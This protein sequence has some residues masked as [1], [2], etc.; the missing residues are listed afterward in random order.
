MRNPMK[1]VIAI[2]VATLLV[3]H[4]G[5]TKNQGQSGN[6][7]ASATKPVATAPTT[8]PNGGAAVADDRIIRIDAGA[9]VGHTD[10]QG[11]VWL[12]DKGFVGGDVVDRGAVTIEGTKLQK[13]YRTERW[14]MTAYELPVPNGRYRVRLRFVETYDGTDAAGQRVFTV[15]A[16]DQKVEDLDVFKEA[17]GRNKHIVKTLQ[18]I[19]V[20]DGKLKI[21]FTAAEGMNTMISGIEIFPPGTR[22]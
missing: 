3:W 12:A 7:G 2:G 6:G 19:D 14:G 21:T 4:A 13:V 18:N 22:P 11:H 16:G 20:T 1:L 5:C 15:A 17:G 8:R 10:E 9:T